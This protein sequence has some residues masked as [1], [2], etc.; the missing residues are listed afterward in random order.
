[1]LDPWGEISPDPKRRA[2]AVASVA[3]S[4]SHCAQTCAASRTVSNAG[5]LSP[6][7]ITGV[8]VSRLVPAEDL[9]AHPPRCALRLLLPG[10]FR[11]T[12]INQ[13]AAIGARLDYPA[14]GPGFE[15]K[16]PAICADENVVEVAERGGKVMR[17]RPAIRG[18]GVQ[19]GAHAGFG[20]GAPRVTPD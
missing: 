4:S 12:A 9:R 16:D 18:Q 10:T 6:V 2:P 20:A 3:N 8:T 15:H 5:T 1:M 7:P 17:D 13:D 11:R 19:Q 14:R